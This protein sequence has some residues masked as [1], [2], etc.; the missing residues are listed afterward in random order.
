MAD[1]YDEIE[2]RCPECGRRAL[3]TTEVAP[4]HLHDLDLEEPYF[5]Q[6]VPVEEKPKPRTTKAG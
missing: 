4:G 2:Y 5:V 3:G 1:L 6:Y